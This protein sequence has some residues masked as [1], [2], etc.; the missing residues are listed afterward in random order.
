MEIK[1]FFNYGVPTGVLLMILWAIWKVTTWAKKEVMLP[2]IKS[3]LEL[4][5]ILKVHMPKQTEAISQLVEESAKQ[6]K[7]LQDSSSFNVATVAEV[8]QAIA[9]EFEKRD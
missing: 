4:I 2:L 3:H 7:I 8:R 5:E 6:T 9:E 1:E